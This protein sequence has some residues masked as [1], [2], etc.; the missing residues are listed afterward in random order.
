MSRKR[1]AA[2]LGVPLAALTLTAVVAGSALALGGYAPAVALSA[3]VDGAV[4][5]PDAFLSI[6]LVRA[7]PLLLTGLAVALAFRAGVWNIGA[8]GQFYA[9]AVAAA[10]I[11]LSDRVV[12]PPLMLPVLLLASAAGGAAWAWL[13]AFLKLRRGVGEVITTL[14]LNFIGI[15]FAE[16]MV[17]GPLQESRGVFPST[18]P[19]AEAARLPLMVP[20][21]RLHWGF[22]L[23][24]LLAF[25]IW[26][27]FR[28]TVWGFRLRA[29]GASPVAAEAAGRIGPARLTYA[30]FLLSGSLAGL[31]GGVQI[32]GV[33]YVLYEGLSPGH[34]YTAIAVALLAGLHPLGVL[35]TGTFFGALEAGAGAMQ[36]MA[37]VP[38]AWVRGVEALVILSVIAVERGVRR[39]AGRV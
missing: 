35:A 38:A 37:S 17:H 34:G 27:L 31:A 5:S 24:V 3:L 11:G 29:L 21:T 8:E 39:S 15:H 2:A 30:A 36:R 16:W 23:A 7:V 12:P 33:T 25:A 6:T 14:L 1:T 9:G 10:W 19:I 26:L 4:G 22:A 20:G 28:F 13:P 32:A 18:D